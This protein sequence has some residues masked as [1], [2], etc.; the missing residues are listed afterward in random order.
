MNH[1]SNSTGSSL[2][3]NAKAFGLTVGLGLAT[4]ICY[5]QQP[6]TPTAPAAAV[7]PVSAEQGAMEAEVM[8]ASKQLMDAFNNGSVDG[9]LGV[10]LPDGELIDDSGTVHLGHEEL[11]NLVSQFFAAYPGAKTQAEIESI[12]VVGGL[13]MV[14]G[15]RI[16]SDKDGKGLSVL[17]FATVWKKTDAGYK[18]ASLRDV[19]VPLPPTPHEALETISWIVGQWVN[20]GTDAKVDLNYRWAEDGNFIVGDILITANEKVVMKS[21]QRIAWDAHE[22][23]FRSWTFDSDGGFGE[24]LWYPTPNGWALTSK[25][26]APDGSRGTATVRI[27]SDSKDRFNVLGTHR[28]SEGN[29]EPDYSYTVV[30]RPPESGT[31]K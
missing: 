19:S 16:I 2:L 14:D 26:V 21:F 12:R 13:A 22:G 29:E 28:V 25:A 27:Q 31:S 9:V 3:R 8:K 5:A 24:G 30:R 20:E 1:R 11:K 23:K 17:R 10:F 7:K 6:A 18:L 15:S 4:S